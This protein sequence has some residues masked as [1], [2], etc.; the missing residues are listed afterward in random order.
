MMVRKK[1]GVRRGDRSGLEVLRR[2][3]RV[4]KTGH[5]MSH[6]LTSLILESLQKSDL[7]SQRFPGCLR[8]YREILVS[9]LCTEV[10]NRKEPLHET[11]SAKM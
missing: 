2:S 9:L 5:S 3:S 8:L 7:P 11:A 6:K 4:V 10:I 1:K